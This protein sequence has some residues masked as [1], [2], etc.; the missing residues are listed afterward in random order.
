MVANFLII[1]IKLLAAGLPV[2]RINFIPSHSPMA[3]GPPFS[4]QFAPSNPASPDPSRRR[5]GSGDGGRE[6][7]NHPAIKGRNSPASPFHQQRSSGSP[8]RHPPATSQPSPTQALGKLP[9]PHYPRQ[10]AS[11]VR[12]ATKSPHI[13]AGVPPH[14][15]MDP[16]A[17]AGKSGRG[18]A[19]DGFGAAKMDPGPYRSHSQSPGEHAESQ[20]K[21]R[22]SHQHPDGVGF[23]ADSKH[24][25]SRAYDQRGQTRVSF[26]KRG[27]S[28]FDLGQF[29]F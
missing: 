5:S 8:H 9:Y 25:S 26:V 1:Y 22:H 23:R 4:P 13:Y 16:A 11:P 28:D 10:A 27:R 18:G 6:F 7:A 2:E 29:H 12:Q 3:R 24:E 20:V 17:Y 19:M 21:H 14:A 15:Y